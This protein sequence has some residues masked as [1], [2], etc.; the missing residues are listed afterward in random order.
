MQFTYDSLAKNDILKIENENYKHIIKAR[1]HK[2]GDILAFR[3]L[4]DNFLYYYEITLIDK[5]SA[6]LN[7][8]SFEEKIVEVSNK[9]HIGW[10]IVDPKSIEKELPYLN[11]LGVD[12][13]TFIPCDYSQNNFKLN[14]EKMEKIL[15]NSS[16]QC[17]RSSYIK[18]DISSGLKEFISKY[19]DSFM[20]N[21]SNKYIEDCKSKIN[22]II[23]GCEGGFS[24]NEVNNFDVEKIVGFNSPLILKSQTAITAIASKILI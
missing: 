9:L 19:P 11:E 21:F 24:K 7:L 8:K 10:C 20:L 12:K 5:R 17:G 23:I 13:I 3:N 22:T 15:I 1:R 16:Q 4:D 14:I 18:L 6:I 2:V